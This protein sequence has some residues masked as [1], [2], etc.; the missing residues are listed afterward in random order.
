MLRRQKNNYTTKLQNIEKLTALWAL[1]ESGL[2]GILHAYRLPFAG[3]FLA[4]FAIIII[5]YIAYLSH[6]PFKSIINATILVLIVKAMASPQSPFNAYLAV[7]FQGFFGAIIFGTIKN[8][9]L[10][11]YFTAIV[12]LMETAL[13]K[14]L[15]LWVLF[16]SSLI[17]AFDKFTDSVLKE[18]ELK[19]VS[20][21]TYLIGVYLS[22]YLIWAIYI[23]Y[24]ANKLP[25]KIYER[26]LMVADL[27]K[28]E[29]LENPTK[30]KKSLYNS[31]YLGLFLFLLFL[32]V[33]AVSLK[34]D[35]LLGSFYRTL[36]IL[37]IWILLS[38]LLKWLFFKWINKNKN[39]YSENVS[40][41]LELIPSLKSNIKPALNLAKNQA[42]GVFVYKEF[43]YNLIALS[44]YEQ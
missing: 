35:L 2:G 19:F 21:S 28:L 7:A 5:R 41:I 16:G 34:S 13:Q 26:F 37:G 3:F 42:K 9:K 17:V 22:L 6:N 40:S 30:K 4:A 14:L 43:V 20:S 31:K 32:L 12:C 15:V 25:Q 8:Q 24:L 18:F 29:A 23:G 44:I 36:L 10:A 38:P 33:L 11:G 1:S 39:K 27:P